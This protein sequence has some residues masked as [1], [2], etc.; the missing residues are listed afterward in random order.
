M[1]NILINDYNWV[2]FGDVLD[3]FLINGCMILIVFFIVE[4]CEGGIYFF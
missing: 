3:C 4:I 2:I 1:R